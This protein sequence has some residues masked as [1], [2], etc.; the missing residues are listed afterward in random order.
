MKETI[1]KT[2]TRLVN[3]ETVSYLIVGV[4]TTAVDYLVFWLV[5]EALK[6]TGMEVSAAATIA[7]AVSWCAAVIFAYFTNKAFVFHSGD[8]S[9]K[10]LAKEFG[11]FA[12]ARVISGLVV[13][14]MQW[15]LIDRLHMNEYL[16][17]I[18]GSVFNIVFNYVASKAVIFRKAEKTAEPRKP[19]QK[20]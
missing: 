3:R 5:N 2:I 8:Y 1:R 19:E 18:A 20:P 15:L 4:L 10:T 14:G 13:L 12:A 7:Q 11:A 9:W 16:A 17:K 6:K